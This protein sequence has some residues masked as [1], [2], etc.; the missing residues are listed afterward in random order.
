MPEHKVRTD[1]SNIHWLSPSQ[2]F[3]GLLSKSTW[4]RSSF[5]VFGSVQLL[6]KLITVQGFT[7]GQ[8]FPWNQIPDC[9]RA[10]HW[11]YTE[12][13]RY[14]SFYFGIGLRSNSPAG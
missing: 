2:A 7:Q 9:Q 8:D 5:R 1:I 12:G 14:S 3:S 4:S 13:T 11:Y 10:L 6:T